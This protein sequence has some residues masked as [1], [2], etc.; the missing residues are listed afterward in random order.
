M[1]KSSLPHPTGLAGSMILFGMIIYITGCGS[2]PKDP[3]VQIKRDLA[4]TPTYSIVLHDM[5]EKGNF[6]KEYLHQYQIV[7][8]EQA[9]ETDWLEVPK[10]LFRRNLPYL[11]MTIY[12][13]QDGEEIP[14][15]GPPGYEYVGN[16][17]YGSWHTDS[18]GRSFWVFYGQYRLLSD[19]LG[20]GPIFRDHHRTYGSRSGPYFGPNREYGT[21]GSVT[22][23]KKPD[24]YSRRMAAA[25]T[26]K[27][28]F[29][30]KVNNRVGRT[31]TGYRGRST[32]RGK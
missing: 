7:R 21:E 3:L 25:A 14:K 5:K 27:S 16:D 29:A 26:Q 18:G 9:T 23:T 6:F 8:P 10:K 12:A 31:R 24:F 32:G 4:D 17:R 30:N 20:G 2:S 15:I 1:S 28:S 11:G 19:L 22:K 13:K